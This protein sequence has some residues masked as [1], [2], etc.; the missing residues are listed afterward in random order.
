MTLKTL[1]IFTACCLVLTSCSSS[2]REVVPTLTA[3]SVAAS[4]IQRFPTSTPTI[5]PT[6]VPTPGDTLYQL[7]GITFVVPACMALRPTVET[8]PAVLPDAEGGP[9]MVYPE[10]H[11]VV[12]EGYPLSD[13]YFEPLLRVFP[14]EEFAALS[15]QTTSSITR[16]KE[17]LG[18]QVLEEGDSIPLLPGYNMAQVFKAQVRFM[19]FENGSGV[20]WLTELAQYS[21]AVNNRDLFYSFQGITRDGKYWVSLMLPVNAAYLQET[22]DSTT[23]P[24]GGVPHPAAG[25]PN[26]EAE[27]EE[28]YRLM[29]LLLNNTPDAGFTPALNC[30][31]ALVQS[32]RISD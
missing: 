12:F 27:L 29:L 31:D 22:W 16:M 5:T 8:I 20:R 15:E 14:V 28:Y 1:L 13:K 32:I 7:D 21:A 6:L 24:D 23:V 9:L 4:D 25:S 26:L 11:Q 30:L 17:L 10:H 18:L 19:D 2:A 3:T